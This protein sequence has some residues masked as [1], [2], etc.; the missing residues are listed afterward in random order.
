MSWKTPHQATTSILLASRSTTSGKGGGGRLP[1]LAD[2]IPFED[3]PDRQEQDADIQPQGAVVHV[4]DVQV[5]RLLPTVGIRPFTVPSPWG[6]GA[7]LAIWRLRQPKTV[8]RMYRISPKN[9]HSLM[10]CKLTLT[11][12]G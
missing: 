7:L 11:L 2:A 9:D 8:W 3:F 4:P 1:F 10:Y 5:K 6:A 12:S